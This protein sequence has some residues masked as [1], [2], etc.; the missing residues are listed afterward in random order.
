M[1]RRDWKA[2]SWLV[3][4]MLAFV[5]AYVFP[6]VA[7]GSLQWPPDVLLKNP[8]A[9]FGFL[10]GI[11]TSILLP[12]IAPIIRGLGFIVIGTSSIGIG[13]T[14]FLEHPRKATG[15]TGYRINTPPEGKA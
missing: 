2:L 6:P 9:S 11:I 14:Y 12:Y 5:L 8:N 4:G 7:T 10:F 1:N 3:V 13:I 15:A